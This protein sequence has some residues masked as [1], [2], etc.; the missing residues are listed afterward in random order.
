MAVGLL[1]AAGRA[2]RLGID[3]PKELLI[4]RGRPVIDHS[5]AHLRDAGVDTIVV[6]TRPGK[7]SVLTHLRAQ[8]PSITFPEVRQPEPIGALIDALRAAMPV[9]SG[10]D[11]YLLFPDTY[12]SPRMGPQPHAPPPGGAAPADT[13]ELHLFCHDAA[14]G[15]AWRNF[16][17]VDLATRRV[18]EKPM[19]PVGST[20]CWG[21]AFW[22]PAFT[23][24][25]AGAATLTDA[26]N[27]ATWQA[28][29]TIDR[30]EDVGL[31]PGLARP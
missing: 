1:P 17:V 18:V 10:Q 2:T 16:G 13:V 22:R 14:A 11:V 29:L 30:Y 21:A 26:I 20:W 3:T 19:E 23:D 4:H 6:V 28:H 9:I 31:A 7:E 8:W 27:A 12:L 24:R 5:V 25:L 15:Q